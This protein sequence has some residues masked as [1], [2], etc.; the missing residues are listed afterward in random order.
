MITAYGG[1]EI[2]S[3]TASDITSKM[4]DVLNLIYCIES[5]EAEASEYIEWIRLRLFV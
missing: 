5:R 4:I 3:R 1:G 2:F